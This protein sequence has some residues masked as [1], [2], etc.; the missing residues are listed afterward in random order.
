MGMHN[1]GTYTRVF[2]YAYTRIDIRVYAKYEHIIRVCVVWIYLSCT[3]FGSIF[4]EPPAKRFA[5]LSESDLDDLVSERHSKKT[6]EVTTGLCPHLKVNN[7]LL[8]LSWNSLLGFTIKIQRL[9]KEIV[10]VKICV[11]PIKCE[12][13][14][15]VDKIIW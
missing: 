13:A 15:N 14:V 7:R 12:C 2:T 3:V 8:K 9:I 5:S 11:N 10:S 6:K 1:K 4:A